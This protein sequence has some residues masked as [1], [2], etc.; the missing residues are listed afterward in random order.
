MHSLF[1]LSARRVRWQS[2]ELVTRYLQPGIAEETTG[3]P[4]FLGNPHDPFAVFQSDSGRT[5][6]ARPVRHPS[7]A[8]GMKTAKAPTKGLSELNSTAFGLAVYA[9]Q[10]GLPQHHAR[11][12]SGRWSG[13]AGRVFHPQ[14]PYERFPSCFLTSLPP[15]PSLLGAIP[16]PGY[17]CGNPLRDTS[18]FDR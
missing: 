14:G 5:V 13:A 12:A 8:P 17:S 10:C 11:L 16:S 9:S 2:L 1:S 18:G 6:D 4:K 3:S 15:L 7:V